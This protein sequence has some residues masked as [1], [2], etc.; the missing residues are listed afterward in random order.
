MNRGRFFQLDLEASRL[1]EGLAVF[2]YTKV[3]DIRGDDNDPDRD[4]PFYPFYLQFSQEGVKFYVHFFDEETNQHRNS[5]VLELP[6]SSNIEIHD[7][8]TQK[9]NDIFNVSFPYEAGMINPLTEILRDNKPDDSIQNP[10]YSSLPVF[11]INLEQFQKASTVKIN[12]FLRKLFLDFLFDIEHTD[13]FRNSADFDEVYVRLKENYL[14]NAIDN[15]AEYY[16]QRE[17]LP[18]RSPRNMLKRSQISLVSQEKYVEAETRWIASITDNR[19][20]IAFHNSDWFQN[21]DTELKR[22][23]RSFLYKGRTT[24]NVVKKTLISEWKEINPAKLKNTLHTISR[25]WHQ[26][27]PFKYRTFDSI[28]DESRAPINRRQQ[29]NARK[30]SEWFVKKYSCTGTPLIWGGNASLTICVV[31]LIGIC[32]SFTQGITW[33]IINSQSFIKLLKIIVFDNI[34]TWYLNVLP[35][36]IGWKITGI[37]MIFL[38]SILVLFVCWLIVTGTFYLIKLI[39]SSLGIF[40][41]N[42]LIGLGNAL[43]PRLMAAIMAAWFTLTASEDI[44]KGFF[45]TGVNWWLCSLILFLTIFFVYNEVKKRAPYIGIFRKTVRTGFFI[46]MAYAYSLIAGAV[47]MNFFGSRYFERQDFLENFYI[48][49][50]FIHD[51]EFIVDPTMQAVYLE[52]VFYKELLLRHITDAEKIKGLVVN[53]IEH[54]DQ[55][56][57]A[58]E[59]DLNIFISMQNHDSLKG[60]YQT[61][62]HIDK[63]DSAKIEHN[64]QKFAAIILLAAK[65]FV[66][67]FE[68]DHDL[69]FEQLTNESTLES[70]IKRIERFLDL[71]TIQTD[72]INFSDLW[73]EFLSNAENTTVYLQTLKYLKPVKENSIRHSGEF[74]YNSA[75]STLFNNYLGLAL[76]KNI[77]IQ[78]AF[79]AMFVGVF[80]QFMLSDR[81]VN[82][83]I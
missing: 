41:S 4:T 27:C 80:L 32:L 66:K 81:A 21:P 43:M 72:S 69:I 3:Q 47:M 33:L 74:E 30:S 58:N 77:L 65:E 15:K 61:L 34:S 62:M 78:F 37:V 18:S 48:N 83:P 1:A 63:N 73:C 39:L 36:G 10:S 67:E 60:M 8:L 12:G 82:D 9:L 42:L 45:D 50:V 59:D 29:D 55:I 31:L 7:N 38:A 44:F 64:Y 71:P 2:S 22:L 24:N 20:E 54:F 5:L 76:C 46:I 6:I 35:N 79:I 11:G 26:V 28:K 57:V 25:W 51:K 40:S 49:H 53:Q 23:Y 75:N 19:S 56:E 70:R 13:V 17:L 52:D 16:Y 68:V 14:Y